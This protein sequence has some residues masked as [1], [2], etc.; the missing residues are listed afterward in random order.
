[1]LKVSEGEIT[2]GRGGGDLGFGIDL[3]TRR[4]ES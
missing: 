4:V 3:S 2:G 1:M